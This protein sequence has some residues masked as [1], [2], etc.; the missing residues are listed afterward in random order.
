MIKICSLDFLN[1]DCF[2]T[3]VM[4]AD[5]R[6]LFNSDDK[7]TPERLL[8]LYFKEI[9][10]KEAIVEKNSK[11]TELSSTPASSNKE[12]RV[13]QPGIAST[14]SVSEN[15]SGPKTLEVS[16]LS[17]E[18]VAASP[19]TVEMSATAG[20]SKSSISSFGASKSESSSV[21]V[22]E[23]AEDPQLEFNE[24]LAKRISKNSVK[25]GEVL[26]FSKA[27]LQELEQAAYYH[28]IGI[29]NFKKSDSIK[30]GFRKLKAAASYDMI[31]GS[32]KLP[33]QIADVAR[34]CAYDYD[35]N[36]F[37]LDSKVP[38]CHII[39]VVSAYEEIL[40]KNNSKQAALL[41]MLQFGGNKFNIFVLHK[42]I[43]I[44]RDMNE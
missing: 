9:Y 43:R 33:E 35:C 44:M 32:L 29:S 10:A 14:S 5:G 21:D 23:K 7:I 40:A 39:S 12:A 42:F 30:K 4:T 15:V 3:D 8:I 18:P 2:E 25:V 28:N 34:S 26:G 1:K 37:K 38:F 27:E 16:D 13:S 31:L 11:Q 17:A 41:K 20:S 6:V 19:K 22:A 24:E 36:A